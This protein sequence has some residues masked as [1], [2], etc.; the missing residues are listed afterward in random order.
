VDGQAEKADA[1]SL[2]LAKLQGGDSAQDAGGG[3]KTGA[4]PEPPADAVEAPAVSAVVP[5]AEACQPASWEEEIILNLPE[6]DPV[7][8]MLLHKGHGDGLDE[9]E[10]PEVELELDEAVVEEIVEEAD[11]GEPSP[12][13]GDGFV[14]VDFDFDDGE[15]DFLDNP[16]LVS[17]GS[18][19]EDGEIIYTFDELLTK[20]KEGVD[21]QLDR[22]D[23]ENHY[24]LGIAYKE[25]GL[26]DEAIAEFRIASADPH[27]QVSC[28]T[29]EGICCRDKGDFERAEDV[30][31]EAGARNALNAEEVLCLS[32]ELAL[33]YEQTSRS[34]EAKALYKEIW[35]Q[36][37]D[38][39]DVRDKARDGAEPDDDIEEISDLE[40]ID[41]E[42]EEE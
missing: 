30:F 34:D 25:M 15:L 19:G 1:M 3:A 27:R 17:A 4:E 23:T 37:P 26:L 38:Y 40:I 42:S 24:N 8:V 5:P 39:R 18:T 20:F 7:R 21:R 35:Q 2:L 32:Y 10:L 28:L 31:L 33:L 16:A 22:S 36:R 14:A 6:D 12:S 41:L 13:S 11:V 9:A 29:L